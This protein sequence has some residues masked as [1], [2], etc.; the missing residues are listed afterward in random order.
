MVT[1]QYYPE[2]LGAVVPGNAT[3]PKF[4]CASKTATVPEMSTLFITYVQDEKQLIFFPSFSSVLSSYCVL[5]LKTRLRCK[6]KKNSFAVCL[7]QNIFSSA[8]GLIN[9]SPCG[10]G[11]T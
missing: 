10:V 2:I 5:P 4:S 3:G 1:I 11:K 9:N 6:K 8:W 7:R